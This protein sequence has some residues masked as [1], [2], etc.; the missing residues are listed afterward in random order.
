MITVPVESTCLIDR[1]LILEVGMADGE[2]WKVSESRMSRMETFPEVPRLRPILSRA[3]MAVETSFELLTGRVRLTGEIPLVELIE[4]ARNST[5][6]ISHQRVVE[7]LGTRA[8]S[9]HFTAYR[10]DLFDDRSDQSLYPLDISVECLDNLFSGN[11]IMIWMPAVEVC[12]H[13]NYGVADPSFSGQPSL[14]HVCH[15]NDVT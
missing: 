10:R 11:R 2:M 8:T 15:A 1:D 5:T 6:Q 13:C 3:F 12:N 4:W 9:G 14:G 7:R